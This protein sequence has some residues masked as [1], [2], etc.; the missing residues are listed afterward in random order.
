MLVSYFMSLASVFLFCGCCY[1]LIKSVTAKI[2]L[3][4]HEARYSKAALRVSRGYRVLS[5]S[6]LTVFFLMT[7]VTSF[8]QVFAEI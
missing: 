8:L 4:N 6:V 7:L 1:A 5:W 3:F 2:P